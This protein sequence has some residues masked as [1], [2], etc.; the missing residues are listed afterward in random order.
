MIKKQIL[1]YFQNQKNVFNLNFE[2][3]F[4]Q[5]NEIAIHDMRVSIKRLRLIYKF[6][7]FFTDKQF[8]AKKKAKLLLRVFKS[9]GPLRDAQ[10]QL[11][12]LEGFKANLGSDC[13]SLFEFLKLKEKTGL[14]IF[15]QESKLFD[16]T[17]INQLFNFSEAL[18]KI[19]IEFEGLAKA[20]EDYKKNRQQKINNLLKSAK[21]KIDFHQVRKRIKDLS[22]LAEIQMI[23][24][25]EPNS[26]IQY[27]KQ[28][29]KKLGDWHDFEVFLSELNTM[30]LAQKES[31]KN[32][33]EIEEK[34]KQQQ[35]VILN[36]F[37]LK[38]ESFS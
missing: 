19:I 13:T 3:A 31:I 25:S 15:M 35:Q 4:S 24:A 11:S 29:G 2:S 10:I 14:R 32:F 26:Q 1:E 7:D 34:L 16:I 37:F 38:Y 20:F 33:K 28:L 22:Y 6:L 5:N 18:L 27:L 21:H 17:K 9:V 30:N 23:Q 36:E 8:C 12:I